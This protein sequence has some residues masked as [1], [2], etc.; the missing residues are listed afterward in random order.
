[1]VVEYIAD[2]VSANL[3]L[4]IFGII[5]WLRALQRLHGSGIKNEL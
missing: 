4:L 1:M 2:Y 3:R 5:V